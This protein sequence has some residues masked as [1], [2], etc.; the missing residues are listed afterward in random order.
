MKK[1]YAEAAPSFGML[2]VDAVQLQPFVISLLRSGDLGFS[3][4]CL[5]LARSGGPRDRR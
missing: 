4:I 1:G 5:P 3:E 2:P